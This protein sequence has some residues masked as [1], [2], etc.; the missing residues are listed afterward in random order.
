MMLKRHRIAVWDVIQSCEITGSS[1][2]SIRDATFNPIE[3][4][5]R[6]TGIRAVLL[7]GKTAG[8]LYEKGVFPKPDV[9]VIVLPST[10]AANAAFSMDR[11]LQEWKAALTCR[12]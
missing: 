12:K 10:S 2:A 8:K 4:S 11:L 5:V 1:D 7:N 9:P 3:E 6:N